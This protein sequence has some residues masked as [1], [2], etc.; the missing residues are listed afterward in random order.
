MSSADDA[1]DISQNINPKITQNGLY[2]KAIYHAA[3]YG[4]S[5]NR[6]KEILQRHI[7]KHADDEAE[8]NQAY[9]LIPDIIETLQQEKFIDDAKFVEVRCASRFAKGDSLM[10]VRMKLYQQGITTDMIDK[11]FAQMIED[12]PDAEF[13]ALKT[14][15]LKR[16][17]HLQDAEATEQKL[18][19]RGF[20]Y[21]LIKRYFAER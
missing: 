5:A 3:R 10:M 13:D 2:Q 20:P 19:N 11:M 18:R 17:L 7:K 9:M 8:A 21:A 14:Y 15:A 4:G 6:L 12:N 16:K 1:N